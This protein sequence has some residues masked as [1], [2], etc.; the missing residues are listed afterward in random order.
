[1]RAQRVVLVLC[2]VAVLLVAGWVTFLQNPPR[3]RFRPGHFSAFRARE[4]NA[5]RVEVRGDVALLV[6]REGKIRAFARIGESE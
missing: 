4:A 6:D 5:V 3:T 2:L 1:M